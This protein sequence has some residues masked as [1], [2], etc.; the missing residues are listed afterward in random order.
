MAVRIPHCILLTCVLAVVQL[1]AQTPQ[2]M[3]VLYPVDAYDILFMLEG[4]GEKRAR[5]YARRWR[6]ADRPAAG[7]V[8][9]SEPPGYRKRQRSVSALLLSDRFRDYDTRGAAAFAG[10]VYAESTPQR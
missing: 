10:A 1:V 2:K 4:A 6:G 3:V 9:K 8:G 7:G 5:A